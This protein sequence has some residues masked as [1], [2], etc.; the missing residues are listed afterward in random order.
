MKKKKLFKNLIFWK[1]K[2]LDNYKISENLKKDEN[3]IN[4]IF[5]SFKIKKLLFFLKIIKIP[6]LFI[7]I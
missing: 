4:I 2:L 7:H 6:F 3:K 5:Y 1:F